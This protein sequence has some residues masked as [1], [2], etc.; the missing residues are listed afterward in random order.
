MIDYIFP[1]IFILF[2]IFA[3][4][5]SKSKT[6]Y[7]KLVE[8]NGE[9]FANKVNKYLK[10]GGYLLFICSILWICFNFFSSNV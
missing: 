5:L 2:A 10:V 6:N 3:L 8:N 4:V 7:Q 9:D 1:I